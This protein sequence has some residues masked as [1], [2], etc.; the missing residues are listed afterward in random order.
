MCTFCPSPLDSRSSLA[1]RYSATVSNGSMVAE[2]PIRCTG[3]SRSVSKYANVR[4]RWTPRL[5]GTRECNS[6]IIM[7]STSLMIGW[8]FGDVIAIARLSG[9]VMRMC[10]GFRSIFC[11]SDCG[12]SPVRR[13]T[14]ISCARSGKNRSE[15][16][17]N[18]PIRF[19]WMSFASALI[20]EMYTQ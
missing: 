16:S 20:G 15:I 3:R 5:V 2:I 4:A 12:V 9:V 6:S 14:R 1:T 8:N 18:G 19:F 11:R 17:F 7:Y 10:G 13:P